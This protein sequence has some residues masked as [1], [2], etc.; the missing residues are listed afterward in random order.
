MMDD[1]FVDK[2]LVLE[3][4]CDQAFQSRV[5]FHHKPFVAILLLLRPIMVHNVTWF[6][7]SLDFTRFRFF[8][9][10]AFFYFLILVPSP[11]VGQL[12]WII[13]IMPVTI[14]WY[15]SGLVTRVPGISDPSWHLGVDKSQ[16]WVLWDSYRKWSKIATKNETLIIKNSSNDWCS[17]LNSGVQIGIFL[18][19]FHA[20]DG[21]NPAPPGIHKTL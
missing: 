18:I 19:S 7:W 3:P 6:R 5:V 16:K 14:E 10:F 20:V 15:V 2:S 13:P 17:S 21:R 11:V 12:A 8:S 4:L 1:V 9:S